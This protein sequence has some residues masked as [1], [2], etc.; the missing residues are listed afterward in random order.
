ML[1]MM[2]GTAASSNLGGACRLA[3]G[4]CGQGHGLREKVSPRP[5]ALT[6]KAPAQGV[7]G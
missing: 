6:Q 7:Q 2:L 3:H 5:D 4:G 1:S